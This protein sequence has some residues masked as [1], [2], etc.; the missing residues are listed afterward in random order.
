M[1]VAL[2]ELGG[3]HEECML[4]QMIALKSINASITLICTPEIKARNPHFEKYVDAILVVDF[5]KK[6]WADF[7]LILGINHFLKS[8]DFQ[9]AI[10]NTAQGGHIR[11]L[12]LTAP[13]SVEF[14]GIIHTIRKFQGSF[15]QKIIHR[16]I[17]KYLLL[18][19]FLLDKITIPKK[20]KVESFY[21]LDYPEFELKINKRPS[22][23]WITIVG[24]VENR[25]KDLTGFLSMLEKVSDEN[26][27][28]VFLGKSDENKEEVL[29]FKA[30]IKGMNCSNQ[31]VTFND[32]I[33]PDLFNAY[34]R[35][36]DFLCP[37][38]HPETQS[39]EQY[40]SNQISG[41]FNL[42]YSYQ[43]PL[44][45]HESYRDIEDL[46]NSSIFYNLSNFD[47]I[48]P[49]AIQNRSEIVTKIRAVEKWKKQFQQEKFIEFIS[50]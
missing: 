21:P 13:K 5:T 8:N 45:M 1:K 4:T 12:C 36:S 42:A 49:N 47:T 6:A 16:K 32:F 14:I 27:K 3:S 29:T 41:A 46:Q 7:K 33:A 15:T 2:I 10:L 20:L 17:K 34:I 43:F 48:L 11:N 19:D 18:S 50:K 28:F 23:T 37:L 30:Q 35:E 31:V 44:L 39:A 38:I 9:K 25:R 40:I 22:E 26:I 24:G